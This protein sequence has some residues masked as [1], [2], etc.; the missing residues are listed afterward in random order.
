MNRMKLVECH[1]LCLGCLTPGYSRAAKSCPYKEERADACKRLAC[2][3]GH[4]CLLHVERSQAKKSCKGWPPDDDGV[5]TPR[6]ATPEPSQKGHQGSAV[7]LVAQWADTKGGKPCLVFWDTGSQVSHTTHRVAQAMKLHAF[8]G[9]PLNLVGIGNDHRSRAT[10]RYKVPL[11]DISGRTVLVTAYGIK[12]ILAPLVEGDLA[13][14]R[15]AFPEV[16]ADRLATA[17]GEVSLLVGQDNLGLFPL[18]QRELV[19]QRCSRASSGRGGSSQVDLLWPETAGRQARRCVHRRMGEAGCEGRGASRLAWQAWNRRSRRSA[20]CPR[21]C[22]TGQLSPC[23][24]MGAYSSHR[25]S[26]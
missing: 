4:H 17:G 8:P 20:R 24:L 7:Q 22:P 18:E 1:K 26:C 9:S 23:T 6:Q 19:T 21:R 25:T 10:V 14:M 3:A 5:A 11:I 13:P 12:R 16:P 2:R 15:A